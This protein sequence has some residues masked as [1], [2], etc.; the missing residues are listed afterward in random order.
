MSR[1]R[2]AAVARI[3]R[4]RLQWGLH[5]GT[6]R[7]G[8]RIPGIRELAME[9]AVD[10]RTALR[11]CRVL[12]QE[13]LIE[14]RR[15]SG[16]Y[17]ASRRVL[18][19]SLTDAQASVVDLLCTA[20]D[21]GICPGDLGRL[22]ESSFYRRPVRVACVE[23]NADHAAAIASMAAREYAVVAVAASIEE[24]VDRGVDGVL[25]TVAAAVTT[26]FLATTLRR[27]VE[28]IGLPVFA[29]TVEP[30]QGI[31]IMRALSDRPIYAIGTD[32]RWAE[33]AAAGLEG[34]DI[35]RNLRM[36]VL[37]ED[38][39]DEIPHDADVFVTPAAAPLLTEFPVSKRA[40]PFRYSLPPTEARGL[41]SAI[42]AEHGRSRSRNSSDGNANRTN[43]N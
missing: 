11:A 19:P 38:D 37:G 17:V 40:W 41:I 35:G 39:L 29:A 28:P 42:V 13:G 18:A 21:R 20:L 22:L 33:R 4:N 6:I 3:M 27:L 43:E 16:M 31:E 1:E 9:F 7:V 23:A 30:S 14:T 8:D 10:T 15:R 24:V 2:A 32:R 34:T 26:S 36:F 12:E 5:T 25:S